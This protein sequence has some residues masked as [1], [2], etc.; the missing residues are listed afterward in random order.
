MR[1][2]VWL[3]VTAYLLIAGL[4]FF[5]TVNSWDG[6]IYVSDLKIKGLS[7]RVPAAIHK[8]LDF[9]RLDGAALLN[10]SQKRLLT[11]AK[12]IMDHDGVGL[13]FG[14]FVIRTADGQRQLACD[15]YDR[16]TVKLV[17]DGMAASGEKPEMII[18]APCFTAADLTRTEPIRI[19]TRR[20]EAENPV[21]MD[22]NY[23]DV[24]G[25][26][27]QFRNM[28]SRWPKRW[29]VTGVKLYRESEPG[30]EIQVDQN[31]IREHS[32]KSL[33]VIWP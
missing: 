18:S 11:A 4:G 30:R 3:G 28:T 14:Q 26:S 6:M 13:E 22:L 24:V 16:V 8:E 23:P 2:S 32:K 31:E 29:A 20:I 7:G 17:A 19:P 15:Y 5:A 33:I 27:F 1:K 12:V 9:S 21:D 25:T 10:A